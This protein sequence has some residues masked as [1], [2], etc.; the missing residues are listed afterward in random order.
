[1]DDE[2]EDE[3]EDAEFKKETRPAYFTPDA[4]LSRLVIMIS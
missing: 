2:D 3:D 4:L 1:M